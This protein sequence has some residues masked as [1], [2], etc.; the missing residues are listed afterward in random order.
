MQGVIRLVNADDGLIAIETE[1]G[2]YTVCGLMGDDE[3]AVGD[4][5]SGPLEAVGEQTISNDTRGVAM[6]VYIED[7]ELSAD[8]AQEKL[9]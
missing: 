8:A 5:L 2:R 1:R 9:G 4:A 7:T 6:L 3:V